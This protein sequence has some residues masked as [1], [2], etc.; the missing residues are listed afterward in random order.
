MRWRQ[1]WTERPSKRQ[2]RI[3]GRARSSC[4][5][6]GGWLP[7]MFVSWATTTAQQAGLRFNDRIRKVGERTVGSPQ[8]FSAL[9]LGQ[10]GSQ[11][12]QIERDGE[13]RTLPVKLPR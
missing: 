13:L 9:I 1:S 4:I 3:R 2:G 6:P 7:S 10:S 5:H 11:S 8:Q 12:L